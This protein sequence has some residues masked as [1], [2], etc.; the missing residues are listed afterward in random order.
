MLVEY[1]P[2]N[3]SSPAVT[4]WERFTAWEHSLV[5]RWQRVQLP[6]RLNRFL[7]AFIRLGDGWAWGLVALALYTS[8]PW[9]QFRAMATQALLAVAISLPVYWVLKL[10]LRRVR[11]F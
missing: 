3:E 1:D 5:E 4:R 11:P 2:A 7:V 9:L 10:G 6:L 8:M